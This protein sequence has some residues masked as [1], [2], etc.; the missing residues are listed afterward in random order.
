M[1]ALKAF[2]RVTLNPLTA[3]HL[4]MCSKRSTIKPRKLSPH[5]I[6]QKK[7]AKF[8]MDFCHSSFDRSN[9]I[10]FALSNVDYSIF[11][12]IFGR[13]SSTTKQVDREK[14]CHKFEPCHTVCPPCDFDTFLVV[15]CSH[16]H[17]Q[18]KLFLNPLRID[19]SMSKPTF[20]RH[21][22]IRV[23]QF[24]KSFQILWGT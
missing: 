17:P 21:T 7:Q 4:C 16:I 11:L 3:C 18:D 10:F 8:N 23:F 24:S 12:Y 19:P 20:C 1:R 9:S 13:S 14:K 15:Q 22:N 2:F 5:L 6:Y